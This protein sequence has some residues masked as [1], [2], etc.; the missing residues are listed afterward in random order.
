M[1]PQDVRRIALELPA[2]TE[3]SHF[4]KP[5]FRVGDR[6]FATLP[7]DGNAVVKL[8]RDQQEMMCASGPAIFQP[9]AGGWG[10]QGWTVLML[11]AA[12][13]KTLRS[14]LV[15]AWRNTAPITLRK[16]FDLAGGTA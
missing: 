13:E 12:D 3:K 4:G 15:T 8:T 11:A 14:A 9:V 1:T 16:A 5:D 7:E 6:V 10:K 2:A